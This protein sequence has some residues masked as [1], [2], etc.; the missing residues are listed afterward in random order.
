MSTKTIQP[1]KL[2]RRRFIQSSLAATAGMLHPIS[3]YATQFTDGAESVEAIVI[4][5]G[6]GGAVAA[7]RLGQAGIETTKSRVSPL[8]AERGGAG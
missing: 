6:F 1:L 3:A 5:S 2:N 4:G 7:L 8:S